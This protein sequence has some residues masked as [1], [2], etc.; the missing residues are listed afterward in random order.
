[1][2]TIKFKVCYYNDM[3]DRLITI[4]TT[5]KYEEAEYFALHYDGEAKDVFINKVWVKEKV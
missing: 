3:A 4:F 1:M 5:A 2:R